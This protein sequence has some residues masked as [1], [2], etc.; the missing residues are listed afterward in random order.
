[1]SDIRRMKRYA[2]LLAVMSAAFLY[3]V[4]QTRNFNAPSTALDAVGSG[5]NVE[6]RKL[7]TPVPPLKLPD[8]LSV[9]LQSPGMTDQ[10]TLRMRTILSAGLRSESTSPATQQT[11][12]DMTGTPVEIIQNMATA[13]PVR[14]TNTTFIGT[15]L[16]AAY[17]MA[18]A[19]N[20]EDNLNKKGD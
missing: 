18:A 5:D 4:Y 6:A 9:S 12:T 1:M 13:N 16:E 19:N 7:S 10:P 8:P 11:D 3:F 17:R 2:T 20:Q 15:P 14:R